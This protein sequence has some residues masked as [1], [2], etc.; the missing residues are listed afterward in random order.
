M[1]KLV[2]LNGEVQ[3]LDNAVVPAGDHAHLYGDGLFEGIR[4]YGGKVFKLDEHL[5]RLYNGIKF[6]EFEMHISKSELKQSILDLRKESGIDAGYVRLNVTRGTGLGLDPRNI[7]RRP[8]VMIMISTL[9][10]YPKEAYELGLKAVT[11]ST[12]VFPAQCLDPR[13]KTIGRYVAN[14]QAKLEANRQGAGEGIM[15]NTE[16]YLAEA[17]GD[18]IFLIKNGIVRTPHISCGILGGITRQTVIDLAR[19][20]G[21]DVREEVLTLYDLVSADEAFLTGTA[22]E[23]IPLVS[24]DARKIGCGTP[25]ETTHRIMAL[26]SEATK[27]GA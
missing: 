12:R 14:I 16:G 27:D 6:L 1:R 9:A 15:L 13:L 18:N 5:D 26:F 11:V 24:L 19:K 25:G 2:W 22:A 8:N 17:T 20:D 23:V 3:D 21:L 7:D 10:L 4:I